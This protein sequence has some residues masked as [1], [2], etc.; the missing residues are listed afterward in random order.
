MDDVID[1][2][3]KFACRTSCIAERIYDMIRGVGKGDLLADNALHLMIEDYKN[4]SEISD[5]LTK[6]ANTIDRKEH[7]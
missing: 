7:Q 3:L 2:C 5:G 6:L 1:K 4:L